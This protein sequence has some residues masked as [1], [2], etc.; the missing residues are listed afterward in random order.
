MQ[1]LSGNGVSVEAIVT[2]SRIFIAAGIFLLFTYFLASAVVQIS[3]SLS[4]GSIA[5][6]VVPLGVIG[7]ILL[8]LTAS[9][10]MVVGGSTLSVGR[11]L[12][13]LVVSLVATL[14]AIA[15]SLFDPTVFMVLLGV[16]AAFLLSAYFQLSGRGI[17]AIIIFFLMFPL[18]SYLE[19]IFVP[20]QHL[21]V[22]PFAVTP[23]IVF[24]LSLCS[25][26][27]L[28][29]QK[30]TGFTGSKSLLLVSGC[31]V[32]LSVFSSLVSSDPFKSLGDVW[33]EVIVPFLMFPLT[34]LFVRDKK[35]FLAL[36]KALFAMVLGVTLICV[37]FLWRYLGSRYASFYDFYGMP[38]FADISSGSLALM[39]VMVLPL[40]IGML[41]GAPKWTR[42]LLIA[43]LGALLFAMVLTFVRTALFATGVSSAALLFQARLRKVLLSGLSLLLLV[44]LI[45]SAF[46]A[47]FLSFRY[48][49]F[50]SPLDLLHDTSLTYRT[51][52]WEAA[53]R[54]LVDYP[55]SGIGFGLW[56]DYIP[57]YGRFQPVRVALTDEYKDGYIVD[58]HNYY[59]QIASSAGL[60]ALT[61][62]IGLIVALFFKLVRVARNAESRQTRELAVAALAAL[63]ALVFFNFFGGGMHQGVFLGMGI[64]FWT[65]VGMIGRLGGPAA[66]EDRLVETNA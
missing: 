56:K 19:Y 11:V 36:N 47:D 27:P 6:A 63:T 61:A 51:Y 57:Q 55:V 58:P 65:L 32:L 10:G 18:L 26:L 39:I 33:L 45:F 14:F 34:L 54:M 9:R 62:W 24:I 38:L 23:S 16:S 28:A 42:R 64:V 2:R 1:P 3:S 31:F 60:P 12:A 49:G 59:L 20:L 50:P 44:S 25:L 7:A 66:V 29:I 46:L 37:Y 4:L 52:A 43:G 13:L 22:G 48:H 21:A 15:A 30:S 5:R 35:D 53:E 41:P 17:Y 40:G 8:M